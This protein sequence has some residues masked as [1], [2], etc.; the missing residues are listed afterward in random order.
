M[1][2]KVDPDNG[3]PAHGH[4]G[5][6][7]AFIIEGGFG[8]DEDRGGVGAYVFE[9]AASLHMPDSPNG[10]IMFAVVHG[11]LVGYNDDG[12]VALI[13]DGKYMYD[14]AAQEGAAGHLAH[15]ADFPK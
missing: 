6:V 2:L 13:I 7:E 10:S 3:A 5:A 15:L 1:L 4:L 9:E 8:Y 11:P 12:S 14:L